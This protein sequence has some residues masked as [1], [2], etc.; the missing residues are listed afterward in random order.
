MRRASRAALILALFACGATAAPCEGVSPNGTRWLFVMPQHTGTGAVVALL[1][2]L[3]RPVH[4]LHVHAR[5]ELRDVTPR[6]AFVF[7]FAADPLKRAV[8]A[9][10]Y[11]NLLDRA[12]DIE[13]RCALKMHAC[14][15]A[16]RS[17]NRSLSVFPPPMH[18]FFGAGVPAPDF[19]GRT[20]H[21]Q[22][23]LDRVLLRLGYKPQN[24]TRYHCVSAC[25]EHHTD[26]LVDASDASL[27]KAVARFRYLDYYDAET[28]ACVEQLYRRDFEHFGFASF[29]QRDG[30]SSSRVVRC[31][32]PHPCAPA[33][34]RPP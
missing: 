25:D 14:A 13:N 10:M 28:A 33:H 9:A 16:K 27:Q 6:G 1:R 2:E 12:S 5:V 31:C 21:L 17:S 30:A 7:M 3:R 23:D 11:A 19:V 32:G 22:E 24:L 34:K 26:G 18:S 15:A 8:S 29:A 20:A 4:C